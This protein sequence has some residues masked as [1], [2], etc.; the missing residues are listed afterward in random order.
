MHRQPD[1][2]VSLYPLSVAT[3]ATCHHN[4][5]TAL[6]TLAIT[7]AEYLYICCPPCLSSSA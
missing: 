1:M 2:T 7:N 3:I 4:Y 6:A 5:V